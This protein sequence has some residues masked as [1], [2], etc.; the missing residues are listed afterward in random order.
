MDVDVVAGRGRTKRFSSP[1]QKYEI[2]SSWSATGSRWRR[3]RRLSSWPPK[4]RHGSRS[5]AGSKNGTTAA[6]ATQR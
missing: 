4:P 5:A 6:G 3:W 2:G 1:S